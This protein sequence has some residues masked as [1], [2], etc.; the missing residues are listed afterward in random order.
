MEYMNS[1]SDAI[2]SSYDD[3]SD[4]VATARSGKRLLDEG[5]ATKEAEIY[6]LNAMR[7]ARWTDDAVTK[8]LNED[9]KQYEEAV[10]ALRKALAAPP[11]TTAMRP[12]R[13]E[14]RV[15]PRRPARGR[16]RSGRSARRYRKLLKCYEARL[17]NA[18]EAARAMA[19]VKPPLPTATAEEDDACKI[20]WVKLIGKPTDKPPTM[21][22]DSSFR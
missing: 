22:P 14:E 1:L 6:A 11:T 3:A 2:S 4:R 8:R 9:V 7:A 16:P 20:L 10:K 18:K 19:A 15:P 17:K 12:A 13:T 5:G 21:K